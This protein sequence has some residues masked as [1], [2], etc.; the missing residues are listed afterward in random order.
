MG[1]YLICFRVIYWSHSLT[2]DGWK[3][4]QPLLSLLETQNGDPIG[5]IGR[6]RAKSGLDHRPDVAPFSPLFG[7]KIPSPF[8]TCAPVH[9][10]NETSMNLPGDVSSFSVYEHEST[11]ARRYYDSLQS[12]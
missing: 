7:L 2:D 6:N 10:K 8:R 12:Q 4:V 9:C 11:A 5:A 1:Q 3:S